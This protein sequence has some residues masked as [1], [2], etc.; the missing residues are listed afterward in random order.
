MNL[1]EE[2]KSLDLPIEQYTVVGSAAMAARGIREPKDIDI[3][4]TPELYEKLKETWVV[5]QVRPDFEVV[6][7][8]LVEASPIM[9]TIANYDPDIYQV[10]KNSEIIDGVAFS[11]IQDVIDFKRAMGREKDLKDVDLMLKYLHEQK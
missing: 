5:K 8:G 1:F 10:I 4:V 9:V 6:E 7:K 3:L 2:V 11:S